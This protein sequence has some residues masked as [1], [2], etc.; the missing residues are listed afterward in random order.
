[1][2]QLGAG[3]YRHRGT[4]NT[5]VLLRGT[6]ALVI[7]PGDGT[8]VD[9]LAALGIDSVDWALHTHHHREV[10]QGTH[11][12]VA[13]GALVAVPGAEADRFSDA[14]Q[15][16]QEVQLQDRYDCAN[17]FSGLVDSVP[18]ARP[19]GDYERFAWE[20]LSFLVLPTPGHTRGSVTYLVEVDGRRIAFSGDL[21]HAPGRVWTIYDLH[22]DY[23]NPDGVNAAIHSATSLREADPGLIAP[24]HGELM[25]DPAGALNGLESNLRR[26]FAVAGRRYLGDVDVP[27]AADLRT[28]QV[29][30]SLLQVTSAFAHFSVLMGREGRALF[31]DF[32][33]A[34]VDHA[35]GADSRFVEH[36]LRALERE[37]GLTSVDVVVPTHYHDDHVSG[38]GFLHE[39]YGCE[40]W[41][42][43]GFA[44]L[45]RRPHAHRLPALWHVPVP[46]TRTF[47][48]GET[49]EWEGHTF[50]AGR[51]P[52]H[53][54]YA[55]ALFGVVDG[56]R[57]GITGDEIQLDGAGELRGGGPVYR[58]GFR[59]GCFTEGFE[60]VAR[61][62]P[63]VV[64]TGHDGPI[65]LDVGR[66]D[67]LRD[68]AVE[69]DAAHAALAAFPEAVDQSLD[70]DVVT[71]DPYRVSGPPGLA[72]E[73][74]V[75]VT[76]HFLDERV[77]ELRVDT[78]DGWAV[79]PPCWRQAVAAGARGL[80][81]VS[82]VP[83][84]DAMPGVRR[85]I[86]VSATVG[87]LRLGQAAELVVTIEE[88]CPPNGQD[89]H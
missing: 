47:A 52:G 72:I 6:R 17:V 82:L 84:A 1:M 12:L 43:E 2:E 59:S 22:W 36:S 32:G 69:L 71:V 10:C 41:A 26:L 8:V 11:R 27:I 87:G 7:D 64:L 76:N 78:P 55:I 34:S 63:E 29:T 57:V 73:F 38:I 74:A 42:F 61:H 60:T 40:V 80:A 50:V 5:Y 54:P 33:F 77:V 39:R 24:A 23:S 67:E 37:V 25:P 13:R 14:E 9:E 3:L 75:T 35:A 79:D 49:L 81:G 4:C 53:T 21:I 30:P 70:T 56:R 68:W 89:A 83:P 48:E 44:D 19:F 16:W 18:V 15:W 85:A 88:S 28:V 46:V 45:L 62:R 20:G 58:N 65:A 31:F 66:L 51:V 86:P